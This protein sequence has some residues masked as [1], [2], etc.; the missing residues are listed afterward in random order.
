MLLFVTEFLDSFD[1]YVIMDNQSRKIIEELRP[2][3]REF[4]GPNHAVKGN[5][6]KIDM[7]LPI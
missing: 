5:G 1:R 6:K 3:K 4:Y 2:G 7:R